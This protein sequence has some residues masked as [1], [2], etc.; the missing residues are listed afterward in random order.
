MFT[1]KRD[2]EWEVKYCREAHK[3]ESSQLGGGGTS[4]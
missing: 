1:G 3:T 2:S 4:L